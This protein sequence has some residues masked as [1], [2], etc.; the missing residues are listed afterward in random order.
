MTPAHYAA[1]VGNQDVLELLISQ[2]ADLTIKD[3]EGSN[4]VQIADEKITLKN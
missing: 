2:G 4:V 1:L 3:N